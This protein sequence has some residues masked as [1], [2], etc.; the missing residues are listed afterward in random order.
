MFANNIGVHAQANSTSCAQILKQAQKNYDQGQ[1]E[2]IPALLKDCISYG[3][4]KPEKIAAYRLII[5][6]NLFLD[7]QAQAE[8]NMR[9]LLILEPDYKPNKSLDPIEYINLY[10]SFKAIPFLSLGIFFGANNSNSKVVNHFSVHDTKS[11]SPTLSPSISFHG[12]IG[13]EW[14][15]KPYLFLSTDVMFALRSFTTA[16]KVYALSEV[17]STESQAH[18]EL[19]LT[20]KI[21]FFNSKK[22]RPFIRA[23]TAF[24]LL[25]SSSGKLQRKS[26][27][28]NQ[29]DFE[30]RDLDLKPQRN[31]FNMCMVAG[32]GLNYKVGYGYMSLD[33]RYLYGM[34]NLVNSEVR[35]NYFDEQLTN[36]GYIDSDISLN[37][38]QISL[39]YYYS[40]YKVKKISTKNNA[41]Q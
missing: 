22:L 7:E 30:G 3:F 17:T 11:Y 1:L 9:Q 15:L 8:S 27:T 41:S 38:L 19:P 10:N 32:A 2:S 34:S 33:V 25:M 37:S 14:L 35:Y 20:M 29:I 36:Y 18:I 24:A 26:T 6:T 13:V 28:T 40:L 5:L 23:G 4:T 16:N 12:G 21:S 39:G 31:G